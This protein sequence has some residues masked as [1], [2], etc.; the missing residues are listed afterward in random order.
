MNSFKVKKIIQSSLGDKLKQ[1]RN[2]KGLELKEVYQICQ[3]PIKYLKALEEER[4]TDL[5]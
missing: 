2:E 1:A 4:W 5:P 3:I